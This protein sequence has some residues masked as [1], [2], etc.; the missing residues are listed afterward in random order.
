MDFPF[1]SYNKKIVFLQRM[2]S[3]FIYWA[4]GEF[5]FSQF[6]L[7]TFAHVLSGL[8]QDLMVKNAILFYFFI[9]AS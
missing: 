7:S 1:K 9:W 4:Q 3:F 6:V 8:E 2:G 5:F